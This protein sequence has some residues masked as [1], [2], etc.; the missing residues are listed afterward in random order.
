MSLTYY[1]NAIVA[2]SILAAAG[3]SHGLTVSPSSTPAPATDYQLPAGYIPAVAGSHRIEA[4]AVNTACRITAQRVGFGLGTMYV[5]NW[6][7]CQTPTTYSLVLWEVLP[8]GRQVVFATATDTLRPLDERQLRP[9]ILVPR[10]CHLVL[11]EDGFIGELP[12]D[13]RPDVFDYASEHLFDASDPSA[14]SERPS[15]T[16]TTIP[17]G[18]PKEGPPSCVPLAYTG[19][20]PFPENAQTFDHD[21]EAWAKHN[22]L[23]SLHTVYSTLV[24]NS[25]PITIPVAG[26]IV[27]LHREQEEW[28]YPYFCVAAGA[29]LNPSAGAF[30]GDEFDATYVT[31]LAR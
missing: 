7:Q 4:S 6:S 13:L 21:A 22:V 25:G 30:R 8:D 18:P 29:V 5:S 3:C 28:S 24:W 15:T 14:C 20:N 16:T 9:A 27:V 12:S 17:S 10:R 1:A 23:A 31:V 19:P 26:D 11:Q 2:L